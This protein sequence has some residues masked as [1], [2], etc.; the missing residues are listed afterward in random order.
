MSEESQSNLIWSVLPV[1]IS[2]KMQQKS[3]QEMFDRE[4]QLRRDLLEREM[5][6]QKALE[7]MRL[8]MAAK[9][10]MERL[11]ATQSFE[12]RMMEMEIK[13]RIEE[14]EKARQNAIDIA[15]IQEAGAM[16]RL[17]KEIGRDKW[18]KQLELLPLGLKPKEGDPF[19]F[20][21]TDTARKVYGDDADSIL[22]AMANMGKAGAEMTATD[23]AALYSSIIGSLADA[24]TIEGGPMYSLEDILGA[25]KSVEDAVSG[26]SSLSKSLLP[27]IFSEDRS[28]AQQRQQSAAER[29]MGMS[30]MSGPINTSL[31]KGAGTAE[32]RA[33]AIKQEEYRNKIYEARRAMEM[34][35]AMETHSK[36]LEAGKNEEADRFLAGERERIGRFGEYPERF[37][38]RSIGR[39]SSLYDPRIAPMFMGA[40]P[41]Y[42]SS[43]R[44]AM[45]SRRPQL[46]TAAPQYGAA[47]PPVPIPVHTKIAQQG[48]AAPAAQIMQGA[49]M[50]AQIPSYTGEA[51]QDA[52]IAIE[53]ARKAAIKARRD[54]IIS[55]AHDLANELIKQGK[56]DDARSVLIDAEIRSRL[57]GGQTR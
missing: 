51:R 42:Y 44:R 26:S 28:L 20:V 34:K 56:I 43:Y 30:L 35:K 21:P 2:Q 45:E 19:N 48:A 49:T 55:S 54:M 40:E 16:A 23:K 50:P 37:S 9:H 31:V 12:E 14:A 3:A 47:A 46:Q 25:A 53:Q 22:Y 32:D 29:L 8:S 17:E 11:G 41:L 57:L 38:T 33:A 13:A 24:K 36:L 39:P 10:E 52:A 15:K 5:E 1:L 6:L 27:K 4:A 18:V 7:E